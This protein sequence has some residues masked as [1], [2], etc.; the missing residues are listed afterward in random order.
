MIYA[1]WQPSSVVLESTVAAKELSQLV[2][3]GN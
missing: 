3:G 1:D 2:S